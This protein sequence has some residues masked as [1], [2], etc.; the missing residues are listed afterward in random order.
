VQNIGLT[1]SHRRARKKEIVSPK[2]KFVVGYPTVCY[3][4]SKYWQIMA[5]LAMYIFKYD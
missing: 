2:L 5:L 1:S 4:C 3:E